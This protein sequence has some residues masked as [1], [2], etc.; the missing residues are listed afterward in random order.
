MNHRK[1][2]DEP[3]VR[4]AMLAAVLLWAAA[5]D[6]P[7]LQAAPASGP[8]LRYSVSMERPHLHYFH[9]VLRCEGLPGREAEFRMPAWT[10]GYYQ[11]MDYAAYV[12]RFEA[13]DGG[14]HSLDWTKTAKNAWRVKTGGASV[15][16]VEYDVYG[17]NR[18]VASN[19]LADDCAFISPAGMF[20]YVTGYLKSPVT[21]EVK[22]FDGW[23]HV[24]TGLEPTNGE[25]NVFRA[26]DFDTLYDCPI[27]AGKLETIDFQV[28]GR[29]HRVAA[30]DLT[31]VDKDRF[32]ADLARIVEAAVSVVGDIPYKRYIFLMIGPG[33]GGLEHLNSCALTYSPARFMEPA[34]YKSWLAFVAHEFF[35]LYN[36]KSIRPVALGPFD[37]DR[38]NYTRMLWVSEGLTVYYEYLI[39]NRAGLM[40]R[41]EVLA[42]MSDLINAYE[43]SPG[44]R[45]QPA[46]AASFDTWLHPYGQAGEHAANTTVSYYV[47]GPVLGLLLDL[48]IRH[49]SGGRACLDDVMKALYRDY[50]LAARRGF[51]DEEF[52][53]ACKKAAGVSL[54]EIFDYAER[55]RDIDYGRYLGYVG[56]ELASERSAGISA[57]Y[58]GAVV[59][60]G[61]G[62]PGRAAE[63]DR[64]AS[65][66]VVVSRIERDSPA[67][68]AGLSAGDEIIAVDGAKV[69][70]R[71][72]NESLASKRPGD[73]V[74]VLYSRRD[75][76]AEIEVA[77]GV[78]PEVRYRIR[79]AAGAG[80][81]AKTLL[82]AWLK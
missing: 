11:I 81:G 21:V 31:G 82:A 35:H 66:P 19:Y 46:A 65:G 55:I 26:A 25:R 57:A 63:A 13:A 17:F 79:P 24:E 54:A 7:R 28:G 62:A 15:V 51:T 16:S 1:R 70:L 64:G 50:Y 45:V 23:T 37:Y 76:V 68:A 60:G 48:G 77:L 14:G 59:G 38:E 10:P 30:V 22:P 44:R 49:G 29:P 42:K 73:R 43:N 52:R 72:F 71:S 78:K 61:S 8:V 34:A 27:L 41:D 12:V 32:S 40:S 58:L 74:R 69:T 5:L 18:F 6:A 3:L 39:L 4:A 36:V 67:A 33:G 80:D 9:V 47:S 56:L 2:N 20:M 53:A 75:R